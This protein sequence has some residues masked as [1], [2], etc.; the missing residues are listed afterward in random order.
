MRLDRDSRWKGFVTATWGWRCGFPMF[1]LVVVVVVVVGSFGG[2]GH[3]LA[4]AWHSKRRDA[5][6]P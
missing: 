3:I 1:F 4:S 6:P 2:A 5:L